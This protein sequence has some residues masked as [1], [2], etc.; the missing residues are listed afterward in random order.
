MLPF[1]CGRRFKRGNETIPPPGGFWELGKLDRST[2]ASGGAAVNN[3]W[4]NG[5]NYNHSF[6]LPSKVL[7]IIIFT[8]GHPFF[9][10]VFI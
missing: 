2:G 3:I 9:K 5:S 4:E 10:N 8:I 7:T 1:L 6:R